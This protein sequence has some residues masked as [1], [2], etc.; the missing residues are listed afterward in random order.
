MNTTVM[1]CSDKGKMLDI[2]DASSVSTC[3]FKDVTKGLTDDKHVGLS[4]LIGIIIIIY[5]QRENGVHIC[6]QSLTV[7]L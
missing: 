7:P 3:H 6:G 5:E 2:A 4:V 1:Q